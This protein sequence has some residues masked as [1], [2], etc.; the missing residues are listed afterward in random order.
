[1]DDYHANAVSSVV[2]VTLLIGD[3]GNGE[4]SALVVAWYVW[5][6]SMPSTKFCS[7]AK[8]AKN[9]YVRLKPIIVAF[10]FDNYY[11]YSVPESP[12]KKKN[13]CNYENLDGITL[14]LEY[15][16]G[17]NGKFSDFFC[18]SLKSYFSTCFGSISQ[19][20]TFEKQVAQM[21]TFS[22]IMCNFIY[23]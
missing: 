17:S 2:K 5:D 12:S 9:M 16:C 18:S 14:E 4:G 11:L 19:K 23:R 13:I 21:Y 3:V 20:I 22:F 8:T 1:M 15:Q 10:I 7:E 6:I